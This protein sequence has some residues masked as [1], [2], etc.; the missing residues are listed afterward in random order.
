MT[1]NE[2]RALAVLVTVAGLAALIAVTGPTRH[3]RSDRARVDVRRIAGDGIEAFRR[4][5]GR[6]PTTEEGL[7]SLVAGRFL[8]PNSPEGKV[9]D[10]WGREYVYRCPGSLHPRSFDLLSYGADGTP[11]GHG[12][13]ED[14]VAD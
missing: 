6:Y 14:V 10:P 8:K 13:N 1:R 12:E 4:A 7:N 5:R 9:R 2:K 11:G 3:T